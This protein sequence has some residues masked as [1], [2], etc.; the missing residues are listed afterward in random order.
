MHEGK[1]QA[2]VR[3]SL[4]LKQLE[5]AAES[6]INRSRLSLIENGWIEPKPKELALIQSAI[7]RLAE[8]HYQKVSE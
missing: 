5:V 8:K 4:R 3:K 7:Q 2:Q 6:G 1:V